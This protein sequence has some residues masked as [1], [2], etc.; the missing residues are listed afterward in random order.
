MCVK[1]TT[2]AGTGVSGFANG[3][4]LA[5]AFSGPSGLSTDVVGNVLVADRFNNHVRRIDWV[6]RQVTTVAGSG[7]PSTV[8]GMGLAASMDRPLSLALLNGL[9]LVEHAAGV[10]LIGMI[11][12]IG[13]ISPG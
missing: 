3:A 8:N 7:A 6:T 9:L 4:A 5:A 1:V 13:L 10:S 12:C 11:S 2:I